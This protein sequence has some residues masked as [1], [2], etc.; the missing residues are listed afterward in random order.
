MC[1]RYALVEVS[2]LEQRFALKRLPAPPLRRYNIARSEVAPVIVRRGSNELDLMYWGVLPSWEVSKRAPSR[3]R[4]ARAERVATAP[5]FAEAFLT[6]RLIVPASG[7]YEWK[8]TPVGTQP[9]YFRRKDGALMG[10]AGLELDGVDGSGYVIITTA[11]SALV[12]EVYHR[13]PAV[14]HPE[15]EDTWLDPET[16]DPEL[17]LSLLRPFDDDLL[18]FYRVSYM[19]DTI[20]VE[21]PRLIEPLATTS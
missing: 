9:Y 6:R 11:A 12:S 2:D 7:W 20:G 3:L 16:R 13:M 18:T 10:F 8:N 5:T 19:V 17:L 15:D 4:H 1:E 21:D 14:L